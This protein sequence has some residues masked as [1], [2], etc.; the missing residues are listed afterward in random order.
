M[1]EFSL[2]ALGL[3]AAVAPAG[4]LPVFALLTGN[5]DAV[6]RTRQASL[7]GLTAFALMAGTAALGDPFLDWLNISPENFQLAAGLV[8]LPLAVRLLWS[9]ESMTLPREVER[10]QRRV[11]LTPLAVP[12]VASPASLVAALSYGTRF[13]LEPTLGAT[14]FVLTLTALAFAAAPQL[15]RFLGTSGIGALARLTGGLLV[16]VAI[17][18]LV[19]GVQSV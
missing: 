15:H 2:A 12:L 14:A 19:D 4:A 7:I 13:G 11:W 3:F 8:M 17:E 10:P 9:G 6:Q 16:V 5:A 1:S 18:L